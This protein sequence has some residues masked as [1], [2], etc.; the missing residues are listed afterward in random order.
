MIRAFKTR[1]QFCGDISTLF[2]SHC[3]TRMKYL[4]AY[5]YMFQ[6]NISKSSTAYVTARVRGK[7]CEN[8]IM[9]SIGHTSSV[10]VSIS[11]I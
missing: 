11:S 5:F 9:Y 2:Q 1:Q 4:Q 8:Y 10:F 6:V 7:D 3:Q